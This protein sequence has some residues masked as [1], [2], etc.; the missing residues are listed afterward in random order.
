MITKFKNLYK[1]N[2]RLAILLVCWIVIKWTIGILFGAWLIRHGMAWLMFI[3]GVVILSVFLIKLI[4]RARR[5]R[6]TV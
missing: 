4:K 5:K 2:R 3:P 6:I 1:N